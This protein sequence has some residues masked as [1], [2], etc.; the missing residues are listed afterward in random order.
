MILV[1]ISVLPVH[2][3]TEYVESGVKDQNP[4]PLQCLSKT[5]RFVKRTEF[6]RWIII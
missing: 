1:Y 6:Y 2:N 3:V 4:E 5:V